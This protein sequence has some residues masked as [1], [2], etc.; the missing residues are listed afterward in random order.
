MDM[1]GRNI[2]SG[3]VAPGNHTRKK[4]KSG[5]KCIGGEKLP[6]FGRRMNAADFFPQGFAVNPQNFCG[7]RFVASDVA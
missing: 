5:E 2:K 1:E 7:V 6:N 3:K 4:T